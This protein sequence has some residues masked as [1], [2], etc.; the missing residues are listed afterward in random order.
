MRPAAATTRERKSQRNALAQ[1][2]NT[3]TNAAIA[4]RKGTR[5]S[6]TIVSCDKRQA[7][8]LIICFTSR[9]RLYTIGLSLIPLQ[10][11]FT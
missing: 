6:H 2:G 4:I 10:F 1:T 9:S 7:N 3:E 8:A 5:P 11:G